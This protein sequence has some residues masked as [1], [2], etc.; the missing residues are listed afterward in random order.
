MAEAGPLTEFRRA[1]VELLRAQLAFSTN[2]GSE[3]PVLL[4][5]AARRLE[6]IDVGRSR[7]AY[8]EAISAAM[9]AG[10]LAGPGGSLT[11]VARAARVAPRPLHDPRPPDLML[12]GLATHFNTGY[13][14]GVKILRRALATFGAGM[15]TDEQLRWLWLAQGVAMHIWEDEPWERLSARFVRLAREVGWFSELPLALTSRA[16]TLLFAGELTAAA[17]LAGEV[18]TATEAMGSNLAPYAAMVLAALR[19]DEAEASALIGATTREATA[20]GE[21]TAMAVTAHSEA[22]LYNGLGRYEHAV[23]AARRAASFNGDLGTSSWPLVELIEAA[24]CSGMAE[25]AV[26]ALLS[27]GPA[28]EIL[29]QEAIT[30]LARTRLH[31]DLARAHLLFGEWLHRALRRGEA[32]DQLR[33]AHAVLDAI[34]MDAFAGRAR[35][36]L[37]A[38]GETAR[39]LSA[40]ARYATDAGD[41]LTASRGE[42]RHTLTGNASEG[43][44]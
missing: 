13:A 18:Q 17:S 25:T 40:R 7:A 5:G 8:L 36:E 44:P 24:T 6:P 12:D 35:R 14:A 1:R 9:F 31:P 28:A 27:D 43:R 21:G 30:R 23:T 4:L 15:S 32:R 19:G 16:Y 34:G 26:G 11:E 29:Y 10:R 3:S 33:T 38:T 42:L 2:R 39:R 41:D 37:R 20:R 22:L